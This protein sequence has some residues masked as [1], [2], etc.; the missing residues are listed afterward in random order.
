[1][2][3]KYKHKV[4]GGSQGP[5]YLLCRVS[6]PNSVCA[7]GQVFLPDATAK[8]LSSRVGAVYCLMIH[9][10]KHDTAVERIVSFV[11]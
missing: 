9:G 2:P 4:Y 7:L 6:V 3:E 10:E 8:G 1:M 5:L 11:I